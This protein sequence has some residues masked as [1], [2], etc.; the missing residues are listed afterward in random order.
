MMES[1]ILES[2]QKEYPTQEVQRARLMEL[3]AQFGA[4]PVGEIKSAV[5]DILCLAKLLFEAGDERIVFDV[6]I[7]VLELEA[8]HPTGSQFVN[9]LEYLSRCLTGFKPAIFRTIQLYFADCYGI[10]PALITCLPKVT[11]QQ[12][13]TKV[14]VKRTTEETNPWVFY[15][16]THREFCS[17]TDPYFLVI[18]SDGTGKVDF[19][20]LFIYKVLEYIGYGPKVHFMIDRDDTH[21]RIDEGILIA[22]QD[23]SYTKRSEE[24]KKSF[25]VFG[26]VR[27]ELSATPVEAMDLA[28]RR[29]VIAIDMLSRAFLLEDVMMNQGNFGLTI[30]SD[31]AESDAV[32]ANIKWKIVDFSPPLLR[33]EVGDDYSY[34]RHYPHAR[35]IFHSFRIGN[36]S[37]TYDREGLEV[38][39]RILIEGNAKHLW[40]PIIERLSVGTSAHLGVVEALERAFMDIQRL[41]EANTEILAI[42][43][44]RMARRMA[45]LMLYQT[46]IRENFQ[47]L[48]TGMREYFRTDETDSV[49]TEQKR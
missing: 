6:R 10:D 44:D 49:V 47:Q 46:K 9:N 7:Q 35:E 4:L 39:N 41:M 43:P 31:L 30:S 40:L 24:R 45:D 42:K 22:T 12:T 32:A 38:L 29:D 36:A 14:E 27:D 23:L 5:A 34:A 13:G 3:V 1:V 17:K 15:V 2:L 20:E 19:K 25:K 37:H 33:T 21:T 8:T 26:E 28:T 16:K 11:G 48:E 18:T